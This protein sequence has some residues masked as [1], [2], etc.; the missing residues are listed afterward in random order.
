MEIASQILFCR[1]CIFLALKYFDIYHKIISFLSSFMGLKDTI[2]NN[3]DNTV[4][5]KKADNLP[6]HSQRNLPK[7]HKNQL[8]QRHLAINLIYPKVLVVKI[9]IS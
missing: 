3:K 6:K 4:A 9:K 1:V 5:D 8:N 7:C 2:I